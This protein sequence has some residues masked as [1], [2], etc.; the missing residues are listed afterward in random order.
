MQEIDDGP[1]IRWE[2]RADQIDLDQVARVYTLVQSDFRRQQQRQA[3][4]RP[5]HRRAIPI[6]L[7]VVIGVLIASGRAT[8][9]VYPAATLVVIVALIL[10]WNRG[11]PRR[12]ATLLRS[13]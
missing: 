5:L 8:I 2:G 3:K 6:E 13:V 1:Q 9:L 12:M 11:A 10:G 4:K 7:G